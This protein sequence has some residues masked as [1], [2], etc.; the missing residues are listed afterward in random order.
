MQYMSASCSNLPSLPACL[1]SKTR[2]TGRTAPGHNRTT[3]GEGRWGRHNVAQSLP[4]GTAD[5]VLLLN[6]ICTVLSHV[7][8]ATAAIAQLVEHPFS[9]R[10]VPRSKLGGSR[11]HFC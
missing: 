2:I 11:I 10:E 4:R 3:Q 8:S 9:K 6:G 7:M 5:C 1:A